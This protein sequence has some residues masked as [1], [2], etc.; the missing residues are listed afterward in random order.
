MGNENR[1]LKDR[2]DSVV[3]N[4]TANI[5][6]SKRGSEPSKKNSIKLNVKDADNSHSINEND[7]KLVRTSWRELTKTEDYK[8]FGLKHYG[9]NMMIKIFLNYPDMKPIWK[10]SANLHTEEEMRLSP[11][12]RSHGN[13]V[14]EAINAAVNSLDKP[15]QLSLL[16][17]DLGT[18]HI[19]YGAK[20]MHFPVRTRHLIFSNLLLVHYST[21]IS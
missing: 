15:D 17:I 18:R 19:D 7:V 21:V 3:Q 20:T 8:K 1:K 2:A 12:L 16:L 6:N 4:G 11:Q 13:N 14:F 9:T 10:F 5:S